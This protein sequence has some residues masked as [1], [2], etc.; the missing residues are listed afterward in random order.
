MLNLAEL[1]EGEKIYDLG[2]G[3]GRILFT[4]ARKYRAKAVGVDIRPQL[5]NYIQSRARILRLDDRIRALNADIFSTPIHDADVVTLYLTSDILEKLKP[6]LR[7]ELKP[8]ARIVSH[9]FH[10]P[11][12][13]PIHWEKF[14]GHKLYLYR[15]P[16]TTS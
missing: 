7:K 4:S 5:V 13:R 11:G 9:D 3:D 10:I 12:W 15:W 6:K 16:N 2:C 8:T 1:D 14:N